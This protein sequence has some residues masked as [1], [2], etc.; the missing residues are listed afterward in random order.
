MQQNLVDNANIDDLISNL[1]KFYRP[2]MIILFGSRAR[3]DS[4]QESDLDLLIIKKTRRRP[5]WRRMDVRKI[6]STD[7]ALD[8]VVYTPDEFKNLMKA[9]GAFI[10]QVLQEGRVLYEKA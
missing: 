4:A 5:L 10:R 3:G 2:E 9:N 7:L 1:K 6:L 8:V